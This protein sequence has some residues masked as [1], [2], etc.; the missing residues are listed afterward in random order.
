MG[1]DK[2]DIP[3]KIDA[4]CNEAS[5]QLAVMKKKEK[6]SGGGEGEKGKKVRDWTTDGT[7]NVRGA[8]P[9]HHSRGW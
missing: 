7:L 1:V 2:G 3:D 9:N 4:A 6:S 8:T 5:C